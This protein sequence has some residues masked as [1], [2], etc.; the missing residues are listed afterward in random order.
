MKKVL[1]VLKNE[2]FRVMSRRSF[3]L[4]ALGLPILGTLIFTVVGAVNK[5]AAASQAVTQI[6]TSPQDSRPEGYVD[7]GGIIRLIPPTVKPG[8]FIAF[9]DEPAARLALDGGRISA[10]YVVAADY[11][12]TGKVTYIRPDF[13]PLATGGAPSDPSVVF[14]KRSRPKAQRQQEAPS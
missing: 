10:Y 12:N 11:I 2:L 13:N 5:N 8:S 4:T 1:L 7:L 9:P 6:I 14:P 3:W